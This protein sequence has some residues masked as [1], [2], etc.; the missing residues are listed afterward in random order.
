MEPYT[1]HDESEQFFCRFTI[2]KSNKF[3]NV[4]INLDCT[5][6]V[7]LIKHK[8]KKISKMMLW[9]RRRSGKS[10]SVLSDNVGTP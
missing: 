3:S 5:F 9:K 10:V 8:W 7:A 6:F 2:A 4:A 1:I